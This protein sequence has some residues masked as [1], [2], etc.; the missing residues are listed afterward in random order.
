MRILKVQVAQIY[1][2]HNVSAA[3]HHIERAPLPVS[4]N[5]LRSRHPQPHLAPR[6]TTHPPL[7]P[8]RPPHPI[9]LRS[10]NLRTKPRLESK[11]TDIR[12]DSSKQQGS[13]GLQ[14]SNAS[15]CAANA[16]ED[17]VECRWLSRPSWESRARKQEPRRLGH[18]QGWRG[19]H[20]GSK[21]SP[22]CQ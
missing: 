6:I 7:S 15:P 11:A 5:D 1:H 20:S 2:W 14:R 17:G 10:A 9:L 8:T 19:R 4:H 18:P 3:K 13:A 16:P 21:S 12:A 22:Q